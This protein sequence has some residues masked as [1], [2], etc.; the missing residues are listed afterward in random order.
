MNK[1][2]KSIFSTLLIIGFFGAGLCQSYQYSDV[3]SS[4]GIDHTYILNNSGG[5]SSFY[6]FDMDGN[7]DI[8]LATG[9]GELIHFYKN[10]GS[11]FEKVDLGITN[12]AKAKSV[13]WVDFD[14]DG[15]KDFYVAEFDGYNKLYKNDGLMNFTDETISSGLP[16]DS[17][18]SFGAIWGDYNRDGHLD[19]YYTAR[20]S[21]PS[22][23][24]HKNRL[25]KNNGDGTFEERTYYTKTDD[26]GK[27][28]FCSAFFDYNKDN[29]PD[30]YIANDRNKGNTLLM[31]DTGIFEDVSETCNADLEID[32]MN[33]AIGD[34]DNNGLQDI[35][36][37]NTPSGSAL[38]TC[39]TD[40]NAYTFEEEAGDR[41]VGFY[42]IGWGANF[43][44]ANNDGWQDLYVSGMLIGSDVISSELYI[45]DQ[46]G[47]FDAATEGLVG[48]TVRSFTNAIGD[49][50]NDG[51][52]DII[53]NNSEYFNSQ[54]WSSSGGENNWIKIGLQ[55]VL[56]NRDAIG[57]SVELFY[58]NG[59]QY[60]YT[61][62]GIGF[63]GQN[64]SN[65]L[66]GL[67]GI[68][69]IDSIK[70]LWPTG[71]IDVIYDIPSN[72]KITIVEGF[73]TDG[74]I[75][76]DP[77][78]STS[79]IN[80]HQSQDLSIYPNPAINQVTID[81]VEED[82][83][84]RTFDLI[85]N[86]IDNGKSQIINTEYYKTGTYILSVKTKNGTQSKLFQKF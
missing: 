58:E 27:L 70:L 85:G 32:A 16:V 80:I 36:I 83:S 22:A 15:D 18:R 38:L 39:N 9:E 75:Y 76:V 81:I 63:M 13:I 8:T 43:L 42:G 72:Q 51:V 2:I 29:W 10:T 68:S 31:N 71:H 60:H 20:N 78:I 12:I 30:I 64:S 66:I 17:V 14:N 23:T 50:N 3:A 59:Y 41:G 62:C 86:E 54:L 84:W 65:L 40:S 47:F 21:G 37:T 6:D 25:F 33:V 56:S 55:G 69:Q 67:G 28:P 73:S 4:V 24:G 79:T 61:H 11:G 49:W 35:Y 45:N 1:I 82:F 53:V 74:D 5:G 34:I 48:D 7:D 19:L 52:A 26:T 46:S 77:L 57:T 44:D